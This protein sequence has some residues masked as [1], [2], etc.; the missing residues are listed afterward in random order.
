[1]S[2]GFE[3]RDAAGV[4]QLDSTTF[5]WNLVHTFAITIPF[6]VSAYN[7]PSATVT[8]NGAGGLPVIRSTEDLYASSVGGNREGGVQNMHFVIGE[9]GGYKTLQYSVHAYR[10]F[11]SQIDDTWKAFLPTCPYYKSNHILDEGTAVQNIFVF[12]R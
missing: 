5:G 10:R 12:S 1:M 4:V 6:F 2:Y 7:G 8:F 3:V 9:S 11:F